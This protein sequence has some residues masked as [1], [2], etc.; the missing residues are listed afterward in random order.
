MRWWCDIVYAMCQLARV[1]SN[2]SKVHMAATK[3]LPRYLKGLPGLV[4]TSKASSKH[5]QLK[6]YYD[7]SWTTT[8]TAASPSQDTCLSLWEALWPPRIQR[9]GERCNFLWRSNTSKEAVSISSMLTELGQET[10]SSEC[11][12][13]TTAQEHFTSQGAVYAARE[14]SISLSGSPFSRSPRRRARLSNTKS[15]HNISWR[16]SPLSILVRRR[17]GIASNL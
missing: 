16:I 11:R 9:K 17:T 13:T 2:I 14:P 5:L 6:G 4:I 1:I 12:F 10:Y 7:A 15:E 3:Q 8:R